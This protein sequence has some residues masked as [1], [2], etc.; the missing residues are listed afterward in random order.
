MEV[1]STFDLLNLGV[2]LFTNPQKPKLEKITPD[3]Y[4]F[5][6]TFRTFPSVFFLC[7]SIKSYVLK[8]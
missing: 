2:S 8:T 4:V 7:A 5:L 1:P 6:L 3:V